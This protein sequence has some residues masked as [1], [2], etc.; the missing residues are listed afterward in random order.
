MKLDI[1][2]ITQNIVEITGGYG[3][4]VYFRHEK[5]NPKFQAHNS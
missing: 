5:N 4:R 2:N 3:V 1:F